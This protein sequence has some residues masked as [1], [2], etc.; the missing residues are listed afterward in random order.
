MKRTARDKDEKRN[1]RWDE[2][3]HF[4]CVRT[5]KTTDQNNSNKHVAIVSSNNVSKNVPTLAGVSQPEM[6]ET[7]IKAS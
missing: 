2:R 1:E 6:E 3:L 5:G 7:L 4:A